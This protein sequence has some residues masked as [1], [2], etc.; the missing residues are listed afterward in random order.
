MNDLD[1]HIHLRSGAPSS[2]AEVGERHKTRA[3]ADPV[4]LPPGNFQPYVQYLSKLLQSS[5]TEGT[6]PSRADLAA[7]LDGQPGREL[8]NL[9]TFDRLR[10]SGTYF[11]G[12]KLASRLVTSIRSSL[13]NAE[14]VID[15][16]CGAGDLL[17]ACARHFPLLA[18][19]TSTLKD[20]GERLVGYDTNPSFVEAARYRLALLALERSGK[21][22][23]RILK[24]LPIADLFSQIRCVSGLGDWHLSVRPSLVVVNP[25]FVYDMAR[26]D[27]TW[28][29]GRV[30]QAAVFIDA[31]VKN[32]AVG[33]RI[34]AI[35][36]D[37]LRTGTRYEGWRR[38]VAEKARILSVTI[39]GQFDALTQISVFLLDLEVH[40]QGTSRRFCW[41]RPSQ[42]KQIVKDIFHVRVGPVVPFR[43]DGNGAWFPYAHS[44]ELPPWQV[45]KA[46]NRS[47]RFDGMTFKPPFVVIRRTSKADYKVRCIGTILTG[48]KPIAVENHLLIALPRDKKF[49]T[50]RKL[51]E[52]LKQDSTSKWM[53]K[54][55]RCRH[56]TVCSVEDIPWR[57]DLVL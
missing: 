8:R 11:T 4:V 37:V 32:A 56:L 47:I 39:A 52:L 50:C 48:K 15:P 14:R 13:S 41:A 6:L 38:M 19:L 42:G 5:L 40:R 31:C 30:S 45:V 27:C 55:I 18:D 54:R 3:W 36:P 33:T 12:S 9:Y 49:G 25:P 2:G 16:A 57:K 23:R 34:V 10:D 29:S 28:G 51:L 53:N 24:E 20:W 44:G 35:L 17:V 43:L 22:T 46:I 1:E 21:V 7:A 26:K